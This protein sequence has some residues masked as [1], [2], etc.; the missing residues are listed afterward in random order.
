MCWHKGGPIV[1][2]ILAQLTFLIIP[3]C[4]IVYWFAEFQTVTE[5]FYASW[6]L[7]YPLMNILTICPLYLIVVDIIEEKRDVLK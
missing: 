2:W 5:G 4:S 6:F 3:I 1:H 7:V